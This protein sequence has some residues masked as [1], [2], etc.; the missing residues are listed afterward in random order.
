M[1]MST[2]TINFQ[3]VALTTS[4]SQILITNGTFA[5]DTTSALS[6]AG[7]INFTALY[8]TSGAINFNVESGTTFHATVGAPVDAAG[9]APTLAVTNFSGTVTVTWPTSSGL[10]T[11]ALMSGDPITLNGFAN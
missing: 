8:V 1:A 2:I 11:Q 9:G 3:N 6:M 7:T 4:T 10:Q 5:L